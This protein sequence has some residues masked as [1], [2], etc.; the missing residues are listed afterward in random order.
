MSCQ[1]FPQKVDKVQ[2]VDVC[3]CVLVHVPG[4][5]MSQTEAVVAAAAW[6]VYSIHPHAPTNRIVSSPKKR[7]ELYLKL[8][9]GL[10]RLTL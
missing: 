1:L 5:N 9:D 6:S 3:V 7:S 4:L 2:I 10:R 8:Q